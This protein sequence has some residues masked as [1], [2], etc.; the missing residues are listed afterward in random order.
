MLIFIVYFI[1]RSLYGLIEQYVENTYSLEDN[2]N[3]LAV[4]MV[5][6]L[7]KN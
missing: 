5:Y 2:D 4:Q 3:I 7:P 6:L 1:D